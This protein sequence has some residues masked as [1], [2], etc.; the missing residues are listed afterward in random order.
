MLPL[1]GIRAVLFYT[2]DTAVD[3]CA[4]FDAVSYQPG[5]AFPGSSLLGRAAGDTGLYHRASPPARSYKQ[6]QTRNSWADSSVSWS[7]CP[8]LDQDRLWLDL[9][10]SSPAIDLSRLASI[11][12]SAAVCLPASH[13]RLPAC[14]W[15]IFEG[16]SVSYMP[17]CAALALDC[18]FLP[19]TPEH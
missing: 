12:L 16:S 15:T 17:L 1:S 6:R 4:Y 7:P 11:T 3:L 2:P 13:P 9:A 8:K 19:S 5:L 10:Q 18:P 14:V